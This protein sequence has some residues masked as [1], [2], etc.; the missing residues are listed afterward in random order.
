MDCDTL[1]ILYLDDQL[2]AVHKPSGLLVH[3]SPIER[4]AHQF[5][6]QMVR[7]Q[8]GS[9]VYPLH[10]LDR[11]TSG[12]L[13]FARDRQTASALGAAFR[14]NEVEKTYLAVVRGH[15]EAEGVIDHPLGKVDLS[16]QTAARPAL[17]VFRRLAAA[18]LPVAVG[19]Y[20]TSRYALL[21]L[22]PRTGR[23]HQLRRHLKHIFHPIIGDTKYGEG[24]HNRFFRERFGCHRLLLAAVEIAFRHPVDGRERLIR[25]P[26]EG[27]F[28]ETIAALGFTP[29]LPPAWLP[30]DGFSDNPEQAGV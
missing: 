7:N 28:R 20:P 22:H 18:E 25:A 4:R 21:A 29:A 5:A 19:R 16:G 6:L 10:R 12:V 30:G 2:V 17:T 13:L 8:L 24:R 1:P 3:R 26:L 15:P 27:S 14:M 9:R 23:R 11:P